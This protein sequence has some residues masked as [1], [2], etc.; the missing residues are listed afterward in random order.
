M[1]MTHWTLCFHILDFFL[2]NIPT[3]FAH[4]HNI[5]LNLSGD[6][7]ISNTSPSICALPPPICIP[8]MILRFWSCLKVVLE[9]FSISTFHCSLTWP[10]NTT[11][12]SAYEPGSVPEYYIP[13]FMILSS[14]WQ[15]QAPFLLASEILYPQHTPILPFTFNPFFWSLTWVRGGFSA[16]PRIR[17]SYNKSIIWLSYCSFNL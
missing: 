9:I 5:S 15:N 17:S 6:H 4:F 16:L 8:S 2:P 13:N 14:L 10:K 1:R 11:M 12:V 3:S 7:C